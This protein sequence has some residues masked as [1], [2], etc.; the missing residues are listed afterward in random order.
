[1][2]IVAGL[3]LTMAVT[4]GLG[5]MYLLQVN[6]A[7]RTIESQLRTYATQ[8][9]QS[10]APGGAFPRP[11]PVSGLD[12]AAQA[13]VLAADGSVLAATRT[14]AGLPAVYAL[15]AGST[16]PVRQKAADGVVPGEV[17]VYGEHVTIGGRPVSII[18]GSATSLRSQVNE[19]FARLL[20]IG[21][22]TLLLL[23]C[24]TV[25]LVVGRALR[26][27]ERIRH[28]VTAITAAD[29][30]QRVP[31][32]GTDDEIGHLAQTMNAMLARLEDAAARQRRFVADASHELRSP[33]TAIRTGL[34]VGLAHP[35]RAPWPAIADRAVRQA[36]RLEDL[37]SELLLLAR[38]DAGRTAAR[39]RRVDLAALIAEI[40]ATT[41]TPPV[42]VEIDIP[43]GLAVTGSPAE[44]SRLFRNI[45]D[46]AIRHAHSLVQVSACEL[47]ADRTVRVEIADD[48][49]GIPAEERERVFDRFV[50]LD[51]SREQHSG[52]AG[53]GLAIAK[54]IV[55]AHRGAIAVAEADGGGALVV[56]G[57]PAFGEAGVDQRTTAEAP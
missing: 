45:L 38:S 57:L 36:T 24:A 40:R 50:R 19:T 10:P 26:P 1:M 28:T 53:L 17:L 55:G 4:L 2:T 14:L 6:A 49:P 42:A 56:V 13:Q 15:P 37:I 30:T 39:R 20:L 8:I 22:P 52:S 47:R 34:E 7:R 35:D 51:A 32:P 9:E 25:W 29:L 41:P 44:L 48:G 23:A 54:A 46:N 18:T 16:T 5:V 3:A 12:P 11:L 43:E 21:L 31:E 33:L 27:V